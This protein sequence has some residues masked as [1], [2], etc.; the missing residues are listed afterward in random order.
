MSTNFKLGEFVRFVEERREGYITRI[1]ENGMLGVTGDDD[2][3]IP[4]L[5]TKVTRV[6]GHTYDV[7]AGGNA[8]ELTTAH[9]A[10]TE[11]F[12]R[13]GIYVAV[14]PDSKRSS[15]V[16]FHLVNESSFQ[17][18]VSLS[19][20]RN[21]TF[22]GEFV[23]VVAPRSITQIYTASL[24]ELDSW[25]LFH[26]QIAYFSIGNENL[27]APIISQV[28]FKSRDFSGSKTANSLLKRDAWLH[29]LDQEDIV[30]NPELLKESFFKV[31]EESK[32]VE[33]PARE[34]D[35]HIEKLR[36]DHQFLSNTEMLKIQL[37]VF[38]RSL[39]SAIVHKMHDIIFI[40][41]LGN[42]TLKTE[43]HKYLSRHKQVKT[44]MDARKEKFGYGATQAILK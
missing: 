37:D 32:K 17:L 13:K 6:H 27:P 41:G 42:G 2:F 7:T 18:M 23:G 40:H 5:A 43:I 28:K 11:D 39:D 3:E 34:I 33:K 36:D 21:T 26:F 15:V 25:P 35:L 31:K 24:A 44:F 4:V 8:A 22:K 12:I 9:S 30:I 38:K 29:R 19:T 14:H 10:Q 16:F 20:E 1:F